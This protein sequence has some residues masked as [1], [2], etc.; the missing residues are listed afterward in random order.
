MGLAAGT[1]QGAQ[2]LLIYLAIYVTMNVG[3]FAFIL[4]MERDGKPVTDIYSLGLYSRVE[5]A[6]ALAL[7]V[8]LFS[9]A[10][11][12]AAGR[13]LREVL[14]AEG[15]G[16]RRAGLAGGGGRGRQRDRRL[17]LPPH[18]LSDVLRRGGRSRS[19]GGCRRCTGRCSAVCGA[20]DGG[21]A[22]S[23]SSA[24]RRSPPRPPRRW[25]SSG[26]DRLAGRRRPRDPARA[27]QHQRRGAAPRGGRARPGRSGSWRARQTAA[28][29]RR[30]RAW[31]MPAGN[32]AASLLMRPPGRRRGAALVRGGARAPRRDGGGDRAAGALRAQVAERRAA[33]RA[34]SSPGSC[35]RPAGRRA[36]AGAR[37]RDRGQP[38]RGAGAG[39]RWS[40]G[41]CR[42]RASRGATGIAIGAGGL[43]RPA[44]AG[45]AR[46][47]RS[48][49]A[50]E[51]FAPLRAAW[52]ARASRL[53]E[54]ITARLPDRA[55]DR[56]LRDHRR[57]RAR[58]CSRPTAGR[59]VLPAA[60][61]HFA[62][63]RAHAARH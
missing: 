43:P 25:C 56:A 35:S 14:R 47:G 6:R 10:G 54:E 9:L 40:R 57:D 17:L 62:A 22:S 18:R 42:R 39:R 41:R 19:T 36:A 34:A 30:G 21:R 50:D 27:R 53:G 38:R 49:C 29:G 32:F 31:A 33:R 45:G 55:L 61:I 51:G 4:N 16:G 26:M 24:S 63:R 44:G 13:L 8:L 59:V 23:T 58:W 28:R 37:H 3:T 11:R 2:S 7:A 1:E 20:R 12:A 46:P 48:G 52:L 5:P 60:E 15:G